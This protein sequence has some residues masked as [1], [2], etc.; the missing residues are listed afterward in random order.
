M[1]KKNFERNRAYRPP[2]GGY[3]KPEDEVLERQYDE[4]FNCSNVC[5]ATD[6]TG[7]MQ[8]VPLED[9]ELESYKALYNFEATDAAVTQKQ[10]TKAQ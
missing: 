2:E 9:G 7:L 4:K 5:S 10:P 6:C 1:R 8:T 3:G